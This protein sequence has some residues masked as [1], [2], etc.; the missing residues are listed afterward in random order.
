M[1][2]HIYAIFHN[3]HDLVQRVISKYRYISVSQHIH[4]EK[5]SSK[6]KCSRRIMF[7]I[8]HFSS[9]SSIFVLLVFPNIEGL[10]RDFCNPT[11]TQMN[12]CS[13][14]DTVSLELLTST[15]CSSETGREIQMSGSSYV[16]T[17]YASRSDRQ[18]DRQTDGTTHRK[19]LIRG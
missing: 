12:E 4:M 19:L 16:D 3:K 7:L 9:I 15:L 18:T 13:F 1:H 17:C 14:H 8:P 2:T 11:R 10:F 6:P 5:H